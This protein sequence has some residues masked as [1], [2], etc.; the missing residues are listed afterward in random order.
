[1]TRA[2]EPEAQE[3]IE[4]DDDDNIISG[5]DV[6]AR[7]PSGEGAVVIVEIGE[8]DGNNGNTGGQCVDLLLHSST[9]G[10]WKPISI[11][12]VKLGF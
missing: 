9:S 5:T 3:L 12:G 10:V 11:W 8:N 1:M 7:E 6:E 4:V 2:S